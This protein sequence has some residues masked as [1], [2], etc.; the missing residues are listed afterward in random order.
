MGKWNAY[1]RIDRP[2]QMLKNLRKRHLSSKGRKKIFFRACLK[3][4][5]NVAQLRHRHR[6][7]FLS[8]RRFVAGRRRHIVRRRGRRVEYWDDGY[9]RDDG[10]TY[11]NKNSKQRQKKRRCCRSSHHDDGVEDGTKRCYFC[12]K[13]SPR[14]HWTADIDIGF[15]ALPKI[16]FL[17]ALMMYMLAHSNVAK[18]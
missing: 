16:P 3:S 11:I 9:S 4:M 13:F 8:R 6:R 18:Q 2:I 5:H 14:P 10:D 15:G 7:L 12:H 1:L 17:K